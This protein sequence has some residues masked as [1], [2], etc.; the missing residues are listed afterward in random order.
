VT[1]I[2]ARAPNVDYVQNVARAGEPDRFKTVRLALEHV[3]SFHILAR[4]DDPGGLPSHTAR[5]DNEVA[6]EA[7][8]K[9]WLR[10]EDI[11]DSP[12]ICVF[13]YPERKMAGVGV[14]KT[15]VLHPEPEGT[16]ESIL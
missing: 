9:E 2:I 10:R 1:Y 6:C 11:P 13:Y 5:P 16:Q 4:E 7:F 3:Y 15:S 8:V 14:M 12:H